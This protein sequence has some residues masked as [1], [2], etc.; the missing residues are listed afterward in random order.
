[1]NLTDMEIKR[2]F[3]YL[4]RLEDYA[5]TL[6]KISVIEAGA[7]ERVFKFLLEAC[8]NP[9]KMYNIKKWEDHNSETCT[10]MVDNFSEFKALLEILQSRLVTGNQA[11][12][13][14]ERLMSRFSREERKWYGRVL[15]KDLNVGIKAKTINKVIPGLIPVF[16]VM[17]AEPFRAYPGEFI[18]QP[19]LDGMRVLAETT[20]GNLYSRNGKQI[21]GFTGIEAEVKEL[22]DGYMLDGELVSGPKF[23]QLI[24]QAFRKGSD[25]AGMINVFDL[26]KQGDFYS[27]SS[28][29]V[30][31]TRTLDLEGLLTPI[32]PH[33]LQLIKG[34]DVIYYTDPHRDDKVGAYYE[35]CI[36]AGFEGV[37]VKDAY[38][39]Y[40][41]KRSYAWQKLKPE[42]TFDLKVMDMEPGKPDTK[43]SD[44]VGKLVVDFHGREVRVGSGLSDEQRALWAENPS[45]I[46]GKTI[47]IVA[48]EITDNKSGTHSLRFPRF[49]QIR[50]DKEV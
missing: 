46:I 4:R 14:V 13:S 50:T 45:L 29:A 31:V 5:S 3:E 15:K 34:T 41:F 25:K 26:V 43:Y 32:E 38:A 28:E 10:D 40:E 19:K 22:P 20:T 12:S 33:F 6:D 1:M 27:G 16:D 39:P 30:Q 2:T 24:S 21:L 48:Q 18:L 11:L 7:N 23:N 44:I 9:F 8:Y 36:N 49:K 42:A 47:E 37:M 17:L 35:Q